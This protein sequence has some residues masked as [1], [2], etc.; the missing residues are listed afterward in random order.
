MKVGVL[1]C[2]LMM[3]GSTAQDAAVQTSAFEEARRLGEP[4]ELTFFLFSTSAGKYVIRYDGLGEIG[5]ARR[6]LQFYL[7][8]GMRGR[9]E[10]MYFQEYQDDLLLAFEVGETGYVRRM[11]QQ[12]RKML[13]LTPIDA[14]VVDQCVVKGNEVHCGDGDNLTTID[15]KTGARR[16]E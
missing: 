3:A 7:K 16:K 2:L 10:R 13:W 15:L 4:P 12:T 1:I 11:N 14:T 8:V 5:T 9:V 6:N